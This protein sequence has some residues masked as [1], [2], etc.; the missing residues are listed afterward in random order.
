MRGRTRLLRANKGIWPSDLKEKS[1]R[2]K[3]KSWTRA[4]LKRTSRALRHLPKIK[5]KASIQVEYEDN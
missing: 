5:I 1:A 2:G 4:L 3:K